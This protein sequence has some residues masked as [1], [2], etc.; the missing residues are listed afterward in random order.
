MVRMLDLVPSAV[1]IISGSDEI[2]SPCNDQDIV[3]GS[4]PVTTEQ[5]I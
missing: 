1:V 2:A 5:M 4:S 3:K